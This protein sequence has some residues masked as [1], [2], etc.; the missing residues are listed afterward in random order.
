MSAA[1][2]D[3]S[4]SARTTSGIDKPDRE[5]EG[6]QDRAQA[7]KADKVPTQSGTAL[8]RSD[9]G[10]NR[11]SL[12]TAQGKTNI[13]DTVVAKIA[14]FATKEI[15]GVHSMGRSMSRRMG[16]LR[17]IVPGQSEPATQGVSVEV[18]EKQAAVDLD[19]VTWYGES[20]VEVSEAVRRNVIERIEAMTGLEVVEVNVHVDDIYV[21]DG[22]SQEQSQARVE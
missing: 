9:A 21:D 15:P 19:V 8:R 16:A 7:T 2:T 5:Q 13:A 17:A 11:A 4:T 3:S 14:A 22:S 20:I 6:A 18:G 12:V 1:Q 10:T